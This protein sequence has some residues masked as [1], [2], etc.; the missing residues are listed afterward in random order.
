MTLATNPYPRSYLERLNDEILAAFPEDFPICLGAE[1]APRID[2]PPRV[3]WYPVI[4]EI[5][6]AETGSYREANQADPDALTVERDVVAERQLT[7]AFEIWGEGH[8]EADVLV[9]AVYARIRALLGRIIRAQEQWVRD[10]QQ[11]TMGQVVTLL[12]TIPVPL[13]DDDAE[14]SEV[15]ASVRA[16]ARLDKGTDTEP[17]EPIS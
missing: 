2:R 6:E 14:T 8:F 3:V 13:A 4:G 1:N 7:L 17:F 15:L 16:R 5:R 12:L 9:P 11:T 10:D